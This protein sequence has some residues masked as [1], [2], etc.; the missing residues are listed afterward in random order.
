MT[1]QLAGR[2]YDIYGHSHLS[3][4]ADLMANRVPEYLIKENPYAKVIVNPCMLKGNYFC[5]F[6][7]LF[8]PDWHMLLEG[9][10]LVVLL[11]Y[12]HGKHLRSCRD[13]QLT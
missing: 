9:F 7:Y 1:V 12:V 3:Y 10:W 8:I 2:E 4:G 6:I 5:L 11:F 13:G